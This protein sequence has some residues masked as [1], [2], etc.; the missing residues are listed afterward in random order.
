MSSLE[1]H[2]PPRGLSVPLVT[3]LDRQGRVLEDSQRELVRFVLQD[4][5][6]ADIV[7]AA[8][9]TGEWDRL[10]NQRRQLVSRLTVE[11]C[12]NVRRVKPIEAWAGITAHTRAET[13]ENLIHAIDIGADAAVLA[14]LSVADMDDPVDFVTREVGQLFDRRAARV[15]LFLYDNADIA[16]PGKAPHLRTR[17]VKRMSQL[18]YVRGIKVTASKKVLGNYTRAASHFKRSGEFAIYAGNAHLIFDLF[19]P[20]ARIDRTPASSLEPLLD[21]T[22]HAR[23]SGGRTA[24]MRCLANGNGPG[25][26]A[27]SQR[28]AA[29]G[30]LRRGAGT[31]PFGLH[32]FPRRPLRATDYRLPQSGVGRARRIL[33]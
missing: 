21:P 3:I 28:S 18:D 20:P 31:I 2:I 29:D 8:G 25:R 7:F 15:P 1:P 17:D 5:A 23:R 26:S 13:L 33:Q 9:T 24:R 16:A 32:F 14:P 12:R 19:K 6:G 10:D 27:R 11:E 4:G 30:S 22:R